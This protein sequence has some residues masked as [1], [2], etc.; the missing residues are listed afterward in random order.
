MTRLTPAQD[1]LRE[2]FDARMARVRRVRPPQSAH[3]VGAIAVL[4]A[5]DPVTF[6]G[7]AYA[8]ARDLIEPRGALWYAAFTRTIFLA[9]DPGNLLDRHPCD[10]LSAD[11]SI[12][13]YAPAPLP[14]REGLRRML[15]PFRGPHGL[16]SPLLR[17]VPLAGAGAVAR[18]DV[19]VA[20][21]TVEDYL[22]HVNHLIAEATLDGLLTG[23]GR[24]VIRHLPHHPDPATPYTRVRVSPD[25]LSPDRL[26]A[27]AY[28]SL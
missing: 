17:E 11:S 10:H 28:L 9:G 20:T 13:W 26:R 1:L 15:R 19:P 22:I 18:L 2:H 6:A 5:F 7:S 24:L 23:A 14:A 25:P 12:A 4:R 8:F 16:A 27:Y 3:G 21:L